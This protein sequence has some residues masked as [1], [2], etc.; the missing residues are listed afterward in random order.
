[1]AQPVSRRERL[2]AETI[3]EIQTTA[4]RLLVTLGWDG[5][6]LRAIARE[7]GMSAPAL[8]R[9]YPNREELVAALVTA[10]KGEMTQ[11]LERARDAEPEL[12]GRLMET[13]RAFRAW[14]IAHPAEFT[15]V[16]ASP[17]IGLDRP[18]VRTVEE[19]GDEFG[20]VF[21]GLITELYLRKPFPVTADEDI[22]PA[23]AHQLQIW[24]ETFPAPLPLGVSK[25]FLSCWIRLYG[26][27]SMEAFQQLKFALTD[28]SAMF[29]S[30]LRDL[31]GL[32]GVPEWYYP[33]R[34]NGAG[35]SA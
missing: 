17:V 35:W 10:L 26:V 14:A 2:R 20:Q 13:S 23:L 32:L 11:A 12:A 8:Y 29:E 4:R 28:A 7:M 15:L 31:A 5:L 6:S 34:V 27:V 16:F 30:E 18:S 24:C 33:P 22:E 19:A 3:Q 25:V 21:A 9:Y 1:M